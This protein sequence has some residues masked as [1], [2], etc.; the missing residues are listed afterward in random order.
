[1]TVIGE[2][3]RFFVGALGFSLNLFIY[4]ICASYGLTT[5][6]FAL[7]VELPIVISLFIGLAIIAFKQ[8]KQRDNEDTAILLTNTWVDAQSGEE[9]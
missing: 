9:V 6:E 5:L 8:R 1:M 7:Y 3:G 2:I 4:F